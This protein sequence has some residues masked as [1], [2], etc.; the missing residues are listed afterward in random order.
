M[1][2]LKRFLINLFFSKRRA[3]VERESPSLMTKNF[4][5]ESVEGGDRER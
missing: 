3:M 4:L 5:D 1:I 2:K